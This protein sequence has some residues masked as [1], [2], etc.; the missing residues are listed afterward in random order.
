M[1]ARP[2]GTERALCRRGGGTELSTL[3]THCS[4]H[5]L[6]YP[7]CVRPRAEAARLLSRLRQSV[8]YQA[9]AD[10][11]QARQAQLDIVVA[12]R[13]RRA[14]WS[15]AALRAGCGLLILSSAVVCWAQRTSL[16]ELARQASASRWTAFRPAAEGATQ[17][18]VPAL[19]EV[20]SW[21]DQRHLAPA[22]VCQIAAADTPQ[23]E[24]DSHA[25]MV[26]VEAVQQLGDFGSAE[27]AGNIEPST[28]PEDVLHGTQTQL[29]TSLLA[30]ALGVCTA[31]PD[32]APASAGVAE[33]GAM[34]A[35][36]PEMTTTAAAAAENSVGP[37]SA[38]DGPA[39]DEPLGL[40]SGQAEPDRAGPEAESSQPGA[41]A[42]SAGGL[43]GT[44]SPGGMLSASVRTMLL[45]ET[46]CIA[47]ARAV[48][49]PVAAVL[50]WLVYPPAMLQ[51]LVSVVALVLCA[52]L[53]AALI[54]AV[55]PDSGP[56]GAALARRSAALATPAL[57]DDESDA[58]LEGTA[59][60][61]ADTGATPRPSPLLD[62]TNQQSTETAVS[63]S[64]PALRS[65]SKRAQQPA[66]RSGGLQHAAVQTSAANVAQIDAATD[67]KSPTAQEVNSA[68]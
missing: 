9:R 21:Q 44:L 35:S 28:L 10:E 15:K 48:G 20:V 33:L 5:H 57:V 14:L 47:A 16:T 65:A 6:L 22:P 34:L 46:A 50:A 12:Q 52:L 24:G 61:D 63:V 54:S 60:Q 56:P 53:A 39:A 7:W 2:S 1:S 27:H 37:Q 38:E 62:I 40:G 41:D 59:S 30:A 66:A 29:D 18:A 8:E 3:T 26:T 43:S 31:T 64:P 55:L 45:P 11:L 58:T 32:V 68:P 4:S 25:D 67:P 17:E 49:A 42:L 19:P 51:P 36:S 13:Q 23:A